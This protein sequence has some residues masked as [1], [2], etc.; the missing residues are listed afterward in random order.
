MNLNFCFSQ[1]HIVL[2]ENAIFSSNWVKLL[3]IWKQ[4]MEL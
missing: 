2:E 1:V 4:L 3:I